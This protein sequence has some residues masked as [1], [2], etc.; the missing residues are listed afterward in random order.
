MNS[1]IRK[2]GIALC[3]CYLAV[4]G[5]LNF[6][7]VFHADALS[8][9]PENTD[10]IRIDYARNRGTITAADG[11][12]IAESVEVDDEFD[13]QRTY[14]TDDLFAAVTGFYSFEFGATGLERT[15]QEELVGDTAEQQLRSFADLFVAEDQVGDLRTTLRVDLQSLAREQLG[16]RRGSVVALDPRDGA[17]L[18]LW[19]YPSFDPNALASH[20]FEAVRDARGFLSP[21]SPDSPLVASA[22]QDRFFPG[23]TFK[24]VTGAS[25]L[26]QGVISVDEPT[27]PEVTSYTPPQTDRPLSNFGGGTCGGTF[28]TILARSCN[29]SFAQMGVEDLGPERA[30]AGAE[31][32][33]FNAVPPLDLPGPVASNYPTDFT[34][35]LPALAQSSIGQNE[36]QASPLQMAVVAAAVANDGVIMVPYTV[37]ELR[38]A[39]GDVIDSHDDEEWR[40][41]I[42]AGT[43]ATMRDAMRGVVANGSA[44]SL[45]LPGLDVGAKTGTAQLGTD[46][47]SSH[48]WMIAFAGPA[49]GEPE[50]AV[51]V[52]VEA[53]PGVS[54]TTGN[55]AAGPIAAAIIQAALSGDGGTDE[56]TDE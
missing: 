40:R 37:A 18:A 24:V 20:D 30:I 38:D 56:G 4:F 42:S 55:S 36:V 3:V 7:Q 52:L 45:Q 29:S 23:S 27:Y 13:Y 2:L 41:A 50:I 11:T 8:E 28:F 35:N 48:A 19:D 26:D 44:S 51:A 46:P 39:D 53:Q 32:F 16:Q 54:E 15:Y 17:V 14:P 5:M 47:P 6:I 49:G 9:R 12:V 34:E 33:G 31:D 22:Y 25:A 21:E 10:I 1:Q 43:A